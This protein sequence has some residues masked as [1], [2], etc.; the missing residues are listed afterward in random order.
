[1]YQPTTKLHYKPLCKTITIYNDTEHTYHFIAIRYVAATLYTQKFREQTITGDVSLYHIIITL[2]YIT[3]RLQ[4]MLIN[5]TFLDILVSNIP[6]T[7]MHGLF[8][9]ADNATTL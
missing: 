7:P 4:I 3:L 8:C 6:I 1:M 5:V 2:F 9:Y